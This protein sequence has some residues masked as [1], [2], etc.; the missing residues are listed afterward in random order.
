DS[1]AGTAPD[2]PRV[3]VDW[4]DA[5]AYCTWA[6]KALCADTSKTAAGTLL[7]QTS[8]FFGACAGDAASSST[9]VYGCGPG[10]GPNDCN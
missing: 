10:C 4:C 8:D 7:R 1:D 9:P 3:C 5:D 6:G 2:F